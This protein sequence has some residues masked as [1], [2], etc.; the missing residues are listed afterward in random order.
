[1]KPDVIY[2]STTMDEARIRGF[3]ARFKSRADRYVRD[4]DV[5]VLVL[6]PD[7]NTKELSDAAKLRKEIL[8]RCGDFGASVMAEHE[9][10]VAEAE[11][12]FGEGHNLCTYELLLAD[13]VDL[14][15]IL[16]AS[17]GSLAEL[18]LFAAK[19]EAGPKMVILFSREHQ[20]DQSYIMDGPKK[21]FET[22]RARIDYVDYDK[23]EEAWGIVAKAIREVRGD[24]VLQQLVSK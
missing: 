8:K 17:A 16:P 6:G 1:L 4:T 19:V 23:T 3:T 12:Q 18:G 11:K 5:D 24:K 21:A 2:A 14:I 15:V 22:R 10:L 20:H 7:M 13:E 9:D